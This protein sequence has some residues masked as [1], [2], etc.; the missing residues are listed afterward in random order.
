MPYPS[1]CKTFADFHLEQAVDASL[2]VATERRDLRAT[3]AELALDRDLDDL[4]AIRYN[5]RALTALFEAADARSTARTLWTSGQDYRAE[6]DGTI[7]QRLDLMLD[8]NPKEQS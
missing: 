5:V 3:L 8:L 2:I 6:R 1:Y 4:A 7:R